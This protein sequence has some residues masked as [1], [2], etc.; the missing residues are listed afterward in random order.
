MNPISPIS[1]RPLLILSSHL[2]LRLS[3]GLLPSGF[4]TKI[5]Y[6]LHLSHYPWFDHPNNIWWR[7][8]IMELLIKQSSPSSCHFTPLRFSNT[9]N[10]CSSHNVTNQVSHPNKTTRKIVVLYIARTYTCIIQILTCKKAREVWPDKARTFMIICAWVQS[11]NFKV[12][13]LY[14]NINGR[15][16]GHLL[17]S[18]ITRKIWKLDTPKTRRRTK[19][20]WVY[21]HITNHSLF[22]SI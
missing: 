19:D 9:V 8:Q 17:S 4:P 15:N 13:R 11:Q 20:Y 1:L 12:T 21:R 14:K 16:C 2:R 10:W 22:Q 3:G 18:K 5:F 6:M 7:T